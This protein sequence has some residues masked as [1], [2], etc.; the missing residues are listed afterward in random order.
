MRRSGTTCCCATGWWPMGRALTSGTRPSPPPLRPPLLRLR[1]WSKRTRQTRGCGDASTTPTSSG[2]P[3]G[4]AR[5][6][7]S[8]YRARPPHTTTAHDTRHALNG[9]AI[10]GPGPDGAQGQGRVVL[11]GDRVD[12][13]LDGQ[14]L[15]GGQGQRAGVLGGGRA[16]VPP[17]HAAR[18]LPRGVDG[19]LGLRGRR[20]AQTVRSTL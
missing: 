19:R 14:A 10:T 13:L 20:P 6:S 12:G 4:T 5:T 17:L 3:P 9:R 8:R 7:R 1:C 2:I 15:L 16:Q 11:A 18:Q